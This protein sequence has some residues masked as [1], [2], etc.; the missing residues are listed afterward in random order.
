MLQAVHLLLAFPLFAVVVGV[1]VR[2]VER[3]LRLHHQQ[4]L[5]TDGSAGR[6]TTSRR[7][8]RSRSGSSRST[9]TRSQ[10]D[11]ARGCSALA[12]ARHRPRGRQTALPRRATDGHTSAVAGA[13]RGERC[14]PAPRRS[15]DRA[16][17]GR[18]RATSAAERSRSVRPSSRRW[19]SWRR[20][21]GRS[22]RALKRFLNTYRLIKVRQPGPG[23]VPARADEPIAPYK[24]DAA[25]A[26]VATGAPGSR[27][28]AFTATTSPHT[29]TR[30]RGT[31]SA[32]TIAEV[33]VPRPGVELQALRPAAIEEVR[34]ALR[35]HAGRSEVDGPLR[36]TSAPQ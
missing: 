2:W 36:S 34:L 25:A 4:L 32:R 21:S 22:P 26:R 8:S 27:R 3:A 31:R 16:S 12:S 9:P 30:S 23:R 1:D 19:M 14:R 33:A 15:R 7:S 29:R 20:C 35:R 10:G 17:P 18:R 6:A 24:A 28:G 5:D 11:A 13:R